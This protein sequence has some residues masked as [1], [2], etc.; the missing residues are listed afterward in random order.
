MEFVLGEGLHNAQA[1]W[2]IR[3]TSAWTAIFRMPRVP[4]DRMAP[5]AHGDPH[6]TSAPVL[7][8]VPGTRRSIPHGHSLHCHI[9]AP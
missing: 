1:S 4:L 6:R 9:S 8:R 7:N 5:T 3:Q 2:S